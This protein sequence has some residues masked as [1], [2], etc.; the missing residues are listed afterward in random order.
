MNNFCSNTSGRLRAAAG[1]APAS[2]G[3]GKWLIQGK[4]AR[5]G[6]KKKKRKKDGEE[7]KEKAERGKKNKER[8]GEKKKHGGN[9]EK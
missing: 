2:A 8:K 7:R 1:A 5:G 9:G 6:I 4:G 3:G